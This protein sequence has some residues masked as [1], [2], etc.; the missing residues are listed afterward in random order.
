MSKS[1]VFCLLLLSIAGLSTG[2]RAAETT[3]AREVTLEELLSSPERYNGRHVTLEESY[4]DGFEVQVIAESL[5]YSGYAEGHLAP[6]GR[7]VWVEGR[8]PGDVY[9]KLERQEMMGPEERYG[10][11]RITGAFEC[12]EEY[13]HAGGYDCQITPSEVQLLPWSPPLP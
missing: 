12:G 5:E 9:E 2:C 4:F 11:V 1:S 13:G 3:G 8:L 6:R 7:M 10:R